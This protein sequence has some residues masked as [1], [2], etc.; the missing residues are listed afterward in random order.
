MTASVA[1]HGRRLRVVP[2]AGTDTAPG[3]CFY[4]AGGESAYS[5]E[6]VARQGE[7][8]PSAFVVRRACAPCANEIIAA[9][10][11]ALQRD[12]EGRGLLP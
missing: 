1:W 8:E 2:I 12:N 6:S 11:R 3:P 10:R 4:C 7:S 5:V 9:A